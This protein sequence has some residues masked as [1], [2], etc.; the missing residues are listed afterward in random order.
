MPPT[1]PA[2]RHSRCSHSRPTRRAPRPGKGSRRRAWSELGQDER[3]V[4]GL[5]QGSGKKP[6]QTQVDLSEPASGAAA[7]RGRFP[8]STHEDDIRHVIGGI[9]GF[10]AY[11][12]V[13]GGDTTTSIG[14]FED[15]AVAE[16]SNSAAAAWLAENL[17]D[18]GVA[19]PQVTTGE[20]LISS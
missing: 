16:E 18:V 10:K 5:C 7:R 11:Y 9:N 17:P 1:R 8:A 15:Q 12:L 14:V 20:V 4:W 13:K 19:P 6:Y 2:G 3:A